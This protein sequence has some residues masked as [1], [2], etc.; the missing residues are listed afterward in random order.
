MPLKQSLAVVRYGRH[1]AVHQSTART[2]CR[3]HFDKDWWPRHTPN[4]GMRPA[5]ASI[6]RIDTR[7]G[8]VCPDPVNHRWVAVLP[9]AAS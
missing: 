8:A 9:E 2:T 7:I 3:R 5:K 4:I 6:M 1:L